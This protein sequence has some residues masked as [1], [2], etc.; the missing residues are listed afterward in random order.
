MPLTETHPDALAKV[1]ARSLFELAHAEGGQDRAEEILGELEDILELA[2]G[3][4]SFNE[5]LASRV[6]DSGRRD[7]S[8]VAILSGRVSDL[9]VRFIRLLNRKGRLGHF[10]PIVAG[11]DAIVQE[12][13]GRVEVDIFTAAPVAAD[14]I[15]TIKQR[16]TE[17]LKKDVIVHP[18]VDNSMLGG[19][20][21]RMGDQLIDASVR[22]RL[23]KMK[24]A[25]WL[26]AS[27]VRSR[28]AQILDESED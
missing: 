10:A 21:I 25:L 17:T 13:F 14:E 16:L 22:T 4:R 19:I 3:D 8:L 7:A 26:R 15:R 2:R 5:F 18:Y 11:Y 28:S 6:I 20:K 1:Y 9:T 23:Q 27:E 24:D 12:H